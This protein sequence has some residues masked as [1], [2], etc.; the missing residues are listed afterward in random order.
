M[1]IYQ[2]LSNHLPDLQRSDEN[3]LGRS[4]GIAG[5]VEPHKCLDVMGHV[6]RQ[7]EESYGLERKDLGI[8]GGGGHDPRIRG[9][10]FSMGSLRERYERQRLWLGPTRTCDL[11]VDCVFIGVC[12]SCLPLGTG[13][14]TNVGS[15]LE[16]VC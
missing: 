4:G 14:S 6:D 13:A 3:E 9:R 5:A 12:R 15:L 11:C 8:Y 7:R 16:T 1:D 10:L 2:A